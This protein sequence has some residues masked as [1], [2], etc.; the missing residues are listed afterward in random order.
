MNVW[1]NIEDGIKRGREFRQPFWDN[2][3]RKVLR[4]LVDRRYCDHQATHQVFARSKGRVTIV[5]VSSS[6]A[7]EGD[8][9]PAIPL[10]SPARLVNP[11]RLTLV[12]V[13]ERERLLRYNIAIEGEHAATQR[14]WYARVDLDERRMGRGPCSHPLLHCQ[15]GEK[16]DANQQARAPLPWLTPVHALEWLLASVY[17]DMEPTASGSRVG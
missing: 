11:A 2:E 17:D 10:R 4:R 8:R 12:V 14:P 1:E 7:I 5:K 9:T 3:I 15:V 6:T 13:Y 16:P